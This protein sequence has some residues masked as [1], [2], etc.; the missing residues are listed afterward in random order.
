MQVAGPTQSGKIQ[1][2]VKFLKERHQHIDPPVDGV[3]FCYFQ[4]QD[5][6]DA[7]KREVPT[8]QF[9]KG[10]PTLETLK[11][12]QNGIL[13]IDDLMDAAVSSVQRPE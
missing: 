4:W 3:L 7:L 5:K 12:F 9:H 13:V 11:N 8:A 1:W 6:Y 2:T 10:I